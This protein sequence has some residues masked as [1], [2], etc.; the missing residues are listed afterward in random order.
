MADTSEASGAGTFRRG[1]F[2]VLE[3]IDGSGTTTQLNVLRDHYRR[4]GRRALFTHEPSDGPVGML[5]RLAL[6]KRLVG[7]NF[8]LHHPGDARPAADFDAQAL[9]LLFAADR[10]DHVATQVQPNLDAGRDVICDRYLLST[11]AYQGQHADLEWLIEINRPAVVPDLTIFL[12]VPPAEAEE[13]MR[14]SRWKKEI[15]ETP[16]Q[17]RRVRSRYFELIQ[18]YI[19]KVGRVEILDASRPPAEV[20]TDLLALVDTFLDTS[21]ADEAAGDASTAE[22]VL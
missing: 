7:A 16:E 20:S 11:L 14:A 12:D 9:A 18:R 10:A 1:R 4:A 21:A 6:Q 17:Q 3:G 5:I 15:F 8:D 13:R 22:P 19:P 2:I